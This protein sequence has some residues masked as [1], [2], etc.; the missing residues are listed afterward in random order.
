MRNIIL[1]AGDIVVNKAGKNPSLGLKVVTL[2]WGVDTTHLVGIAYWVY[3]VIRKYTV[4]F[5]LLNQW[6]NCSG[7]YRR[8]SNYWGMSK[9]IWTIERVVKLRERVWFLGIK[10]QVTLVHGCMLYTISLISVLIL[11]VIHF[12]FRWQL[13]NTLCL[14]SKAYL[15]FLLWKVLFKV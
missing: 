9:W 12:I 3:T 1:Y 10:V 11:I 15:T 6:S 2:M 4:S 13:G 14:S 7:G 5:L 8:G